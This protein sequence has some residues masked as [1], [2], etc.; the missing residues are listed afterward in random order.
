M[1]VINVIHSVWVCVIIGSNSHVTTFLPVRTDVFPQ[2][3]GLF[4]AAVAEG[5]AARPLS[6]V[7]KLVV[8][9]VLKAAQALPAY[10]THV[11]FLSCVRAPVFS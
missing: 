11:R 4:E 1:E 9:E 6:S 10:G 2:R 3:C 5:T 8:F 7:D